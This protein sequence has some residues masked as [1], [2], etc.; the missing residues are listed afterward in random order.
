MEHPLYPSIAAMLAPEALSEIAGQPIAAVECLPFEPA[1][2]SASGSRLLAVRTNGGNGPRYVLKQMSLE[3]DWIMRATDDRH[4][5]SVSVWQ[6][7]LLD[8]LPG[9]AHAIVAGAR[10]R[11]SCALLMCDISDTLFLEDVVFSV[12]DNAH[13]LDA[14]A[15]LHAT[16]W[17]SAALND[18]RLGLCSLRH[19]YSCFAPA[20]LRG[21]IDSPEQIT[22]GL[23]KGWD[24][25]DTLIAPDAAAPIR[26]L[27]ED[28][29]PLCDALARY[30]Q[31]L[32]HGD[33]RA[34][35]LG[36]LRDARPQ[37]ALLDWQFVGRAPPAVDLA[38]YI[39]LNLVCM[40][41]DIETAIACYRDSLAQYLGDRFAIDWWEP[42]LALALLGNFVQFGCHHMMKAAG[43]WEDD[44]VKRAGWRAAL[45]W[46][47]ER[48]REGVR[49][50]V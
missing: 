11:A 16:F 8:R 14:M 6:R 44:P 50:L 45:D 49:W 46:W 41:I 27:L 33:W 35:N 12:E 7:G 31:T 17:E 9:I 3:W 24:L 40:P 32:V 19:R 18:L 4:C 2:F 23:L 28:P 25:L 29:Q 5:R 20:V 34:A 43:Y 42:Q 47:S 30:P 36:V 13:F 1:G 10:D 21:E 39:G 38:W 48:I 22:Q 37:V 26:K 15:A